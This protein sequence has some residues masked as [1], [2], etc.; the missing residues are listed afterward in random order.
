MKFEVVLVYCLKSKKIEHV[1]NFDL[2]LLIVF[3]DDLFSGRIFDS[4]CRQI[5]YLEYYKGLKC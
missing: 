2:L 5:F 4:K 1:L 3:A